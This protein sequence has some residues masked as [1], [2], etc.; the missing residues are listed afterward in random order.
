MAKGDYVIMGTGTF[1]ASAPGVIASADITSTG[2][3]VTDNVIITL[4]SALPHMNN[5]GGLNNIYV[6]SVTTNKFV[7]KSAYPELA[8]DVTFNFIV[9]DAA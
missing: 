1:D 4:T 8:E 3:A 9:F 6:E 5:K 2:S 7:V